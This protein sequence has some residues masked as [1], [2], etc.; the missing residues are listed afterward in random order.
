MSFDGNDERSTD[1]EKEGQGRGD[2]KVL[3]KV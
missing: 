2:T 1:R 3:R